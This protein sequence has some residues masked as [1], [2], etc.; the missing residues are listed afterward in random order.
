MRSRYSAF[1]LHD[2][3][4]LLATWHPSTRPQSVNFS[5]DIDWHGLT[6]LAASGGGLDSSGSVEFKARF[7][8]GGADLEL[9]ELSTFSQE[10]GRWFYVEGS[11]PDSH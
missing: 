9:H 7:H 11:D 8:R 6:V 5:L 10:Q 2:E 4:Y 3:A 1:A